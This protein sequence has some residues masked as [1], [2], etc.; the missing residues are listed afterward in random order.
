MGGILAPPSLQGSPGADSCRPSNGWCRR[1]RSLISCPSG[2][3]STAEPQPSAADEGSTPSARAILPGGAGVLRLR[4][5]TCTAGAQ[6]DRP[7]LE[8][9]HRR[10]AHQ[11]LRDIHRAEQP[12]VEIR[13]LGGDHAAFVLHRRPLADG[14]RVLCLHRL[15]ASVAMGRARRQCDC[16]VRRTNRVV[17]GWW[18]G[19]TPL[20]Y[21]RSRVEG[22][23][24]D[25]HH[26]PPLDGGQLARQ[27]RFSTAASRWRSR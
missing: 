16:F 21:V 22:Y 19:K 17:E 18:R 24:F 4:A 11:R 8:H 27:L 9:I 5:S 25:L 13:N 6:S 3:S 23:G 26:P 2:H 1:P 7:R 12:R 10:H 20:L 15:A 14:Q